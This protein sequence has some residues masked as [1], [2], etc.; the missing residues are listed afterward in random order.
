MEDLDTLIELLVKE[1]AS[2]LHISEERNPYIRISSQL[3][4]LLKYPKFTKAL[5]ESI[6]SKTLSDLKKEM[7]KSSQSADFAYSHKG[8]R[9]RVHAFIDQQRICMTFRHIPKK[10]P[11]LAELNLPE[12]LANFARLKSGYFL[13]VGP[14]GHGKSTTLASLVEI[15]NNERLENIIT[16]EDPIE[17]LFTPK[18]SII[19]QREVGL[20][21][22]SFAGALHDSF[23]A[24]VNMIMVGEMRDADTMSTAVSAAE[25]GHL[26]FSTLHTNNAAQTVDRII[27]SFNPNQQSQIRIQLAASLSGIFSQRLVPKISGGLVPCYELM[28][29]NTAVSNLIR[30]KRTHELNTVIETSSGEGMI[31]FNRCLVEKVNA[32]EITIENAYL[33]S[34]NP[35]SLEKML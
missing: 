21:T 29:N 22:P 15:I 16:I 30:D 4:P 12:N 9:F 13:V 34:T 20:D 23:R 6:L 33:Y 31:D 5:M 2:D 24:D 18:K 8:E 1:G 19:H 14:T 35:R 28:L 17:Y 27:D 10:I 11:S 25:T 7:F 3:A 26:V 32:G